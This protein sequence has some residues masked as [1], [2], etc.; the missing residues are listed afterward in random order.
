MQSECKQYRVAKF[1]IAG[2][3]FYEAW[4]GKEMLA[5]RLPSSDAAKAVVT[6]QEAV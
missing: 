6:R 1:W 3:T 2:E 4:R 5:T